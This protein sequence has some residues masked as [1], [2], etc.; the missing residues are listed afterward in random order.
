MFSTDVLVVGAGPAGCAAAL[1][2]ARAGRKTVVLEGRGASRLDLGYAIE[3]YPGFLTISGTELLQKFRAHAEHF[4]A[5]F[6][7]EDAIEFRLTAQ[8]RSVATRSYLFEALAVIL[9]TGKPIARERMIPGEERLLGQG[10][11][12]CAACDG[13]LYR[14]QVVFAVGA[15]AEAAEEVLA[16]DGMGCRVRW[17]PGRLEASA[18]PGSVLEEM[19][20]KQ[21]PIHWK[22]RVKEISGESGVERIHLDTEEREETLE[23]AALFIFRESVASPLFVKA[24]L[25]L[26]HRQCLAVD[27]F[28]RTNL[29][30][31]YAAGD[32]TC[33]GMQV[34][35]AAGEG[36]TAALHALIY[37]R[38]T[39]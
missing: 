22:A 12:Y 23:A 19:R 18:V 29:E 4:G 3:N 35:T 25:K 16:L 5:Q 11:S 32:I 28:Q 9:A 15:A 17:I 33:G 8:P 7:A 34:V 13:P 1:Y 31:V 26:D 10:V 38:K 21:I 30:G 6:I 37:L 14:G 36:A 27:R 20:R 24:G 39:G 2:A